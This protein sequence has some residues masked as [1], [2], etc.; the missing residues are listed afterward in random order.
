MSWRDWFRKKD[1]SPPE[2]PSTAEP[3]EADGGEVTDYLELLLRSHDV[4][5]ERQGPTIVVPGTPCR[6]EA[7]IVKDRVHPQGH[8][9][10]LDIRLQL[11]RE[12]WLIESFGGFGDTR[13]QAV[14]DAF[15]TLVRGS[16]HV[17][18]RAFFSVPGYEEQITVESWNIAGTPR[19]VVFGNAVLHG[20][21]PEAVRDPTEWFG[22]LETGIRSQ[23]LSPEAH[24]IR[25]YYAH[26]RGE[27]LA[28]E[29]LL[30]NETW[31]SVEELMQAFPWPASEGFYSAR[32]FLVVLPT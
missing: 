26:N 17:L 22:R 14:G 5:T 21:A 16:L 8:S 12:R 6:A 19:T 28:T 24:W 23:A 13:D 11:S 1:P 3:R 27:E 9:I 20:R 4:A 32:L 18:L 31:T 29:A 25:F 10:Q 30:D 7:E 2:T 15:S